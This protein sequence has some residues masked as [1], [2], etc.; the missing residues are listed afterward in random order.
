MW[1]IN[2]KTHI[3]L[4][5]A[6]SQGDSPYGPDDAFCR[7]GGGD[8]IHQLVRIHQL[9]RRG[10]RGGLHHKLVRKPGRHKLD[11]SVFHN[12]SATWKNILILFTWQIK[13]KTNILLCW[14]VSQGDSPF[15]PDDAFCSRWP[16]PAMQWRAKGQ[17]CFSS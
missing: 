12:K 8:V 2:W 15:G 10:I 13:W 14:A 3:L 17:K 6:V 16:T 7:G 11:R 4:C 9:I 5:W 1:Q